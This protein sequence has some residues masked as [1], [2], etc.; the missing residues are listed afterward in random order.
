MSAACGSRGR[1]AYP[2]C[3]QQQPERSVHTRC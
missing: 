2:C 1:C 3:V